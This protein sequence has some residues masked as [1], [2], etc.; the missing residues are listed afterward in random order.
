MKHSSHLLE[1]ALDDEEVKAY[2]ETIPSN[3]NYEKKGQGHY[4]LSNLRRG[5]DLEF[6]YQNWLMILSLIA[7]G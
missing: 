4:I 6:H 5:G 1:I 3:S 2:K 7:S